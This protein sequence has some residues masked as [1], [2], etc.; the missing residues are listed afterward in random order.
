[1]WAPLTAQGMGGGGSSTTPK[2]E[3]PPGLQREEHIQL[4]TNFVS[5]LEVRSQ[6][7]PQI[8]SYLTRQLGLTES[9]LNEVLRRSGIDPTAG[10]TE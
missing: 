6:P 4:G 3:N 10:I 5:R 8:K 2:K 1:M 9:E 7:L